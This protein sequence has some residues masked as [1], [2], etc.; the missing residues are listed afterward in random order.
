M[1][2]PMEFILSKLPKNL[3]VRNA[4]VLVGGT[5][6]A[7]ILLVIASPM[8]TRL[9]TPEDFGL[10]AVYVSMLAI[11]LLLASLR[12]DL[13]I[14][15]PKN[16]VEAAD[17]AVLSLILVVITSFLVA[18]IVL[19]SREN[20]AE[21]LDLP[22]LVS[23]LW[24]LPLGTLFG[25]MYNVFNRWS[26]R[27][28]HFGLIASTNIRK[29][30]ALLVIQ[31]SA[32]KFGGIA[33]LL[34][35]VISHGVG[36]LRLARPSF[37]DVSLNGIRDAALRYK[38]FPFYSS[39]AG[40]ARVL[41]VELPSFVLT[42]AFSPA[43]AGLYALTKRVCGVPAAVIGGAVSQ[44]F[45][46]SAADAYRDGTL[47]ALVRTFHAKMAYIGLPFMLLLMML[48]PKL[49]GII[50]G[51]AWIQAGEFACWMAPW[52]YLGFVSSPISTV[53]A[54]ME[55]QKQGLVFHLVL[56]A[57]RICALFIGV[58]IGDVLI[59]VIIFATV[60]AI[61]RLVFLVWL[62]VVS[63]N[64]VTSFLADTSAALALACLCVAPVFIALTLYGQIWFYALMVSLVFITALYWQLLKQAY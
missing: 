40:L 19:V 9:Y 64:T 52:L 10:L 21:I 29:T 5:L 24:L 43:A 57:F 61:W 46:A 18:I 32:F 53:T 56:L 3:F 8:L 33:L 58:Y 28:K 4:S 25:G 14:P 50:F 15:L 63:G 31:L 59:A 20:I 6:M 34:G 16:D 60:N 37:N 23:H 47:G 2:K 39:P 12:Y 22:E 55:L 62:Y 49:F 35:Q 42:A 45:V 48:G 27:T 30:F 13:A 26:V 1:R 38:R 17:I 36:V 11:T 7:Q 41:G 44:V 54:I 51:S